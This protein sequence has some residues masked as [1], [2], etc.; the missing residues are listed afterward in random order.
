MEGNPLLAGL[1]A[2]GV[3]ITVPRTAICEW[4]VEQNAHPTAA[5]IHA[6]LQ[7]AVGPLSLATV[8][9]TL[10][11]LERLGLVVPIGMAHDGHKHYDINTEQHI[12]LVLG[13]DGGVLDVYDEALLAEVRRVAAQHGIDPE[14]V[15]LVMFGAREHAASS[16]S[17]NSR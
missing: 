8:Y 15:R 10:A 11:L 12:N 7:P 9:N 17:G 2:A 16:D 13:S 6:A 1:R 14:H 4:L 5:E 3:S